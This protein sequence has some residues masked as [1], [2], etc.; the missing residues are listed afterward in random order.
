VCVKVEVK[1]PMLTLDRGVEAGRGLDDQQ[2]V[3][4]RWKWR[5]CVVQNLRLR[6]IGLRL[7]LRCN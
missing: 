3:A 6:V 5:V 4:C 1:R 2:H 7:D